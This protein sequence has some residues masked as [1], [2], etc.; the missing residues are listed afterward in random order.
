MSIDALEQYLESP[1]IDVELLGK[2][3]KL[4]L[5]Q[6]WRKR[7]ASKL[8]QET[9]K[10]VVRNWDLYVFEKGFFPCLIDGEALTEFEKQLP[11]PCYVLPSDSG[12]GFWCSNLPPVDLGR[13]CLEGA[14]PWP[15]ASAGSGTTWAD[16]NILVFPAS[17]SWTLAIHA[18]GCFFAVDAK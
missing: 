18:E 9:G 11:E 13:F 4:K 10:S 8:C 3:E 7:Y 14:R 16:S 17:M 1:G 2:G 6:G 15:S 5:L 12:P